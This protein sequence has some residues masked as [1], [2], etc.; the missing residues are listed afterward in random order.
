MNLFILYLN[1]SGPI[2]DFFQ[3]LFLLLNQTIVKRYTIF[4][5]FSVWVVSNLG[6]L[7]TK[8]PYVVPLSSDWHYFWWEVL[9]GKQKSIDLPSPE[10]SIPC[11]FY[12]ILIYVRVWRDFAHAINVKISVDLKIIRLASIQPGEPVQS[13]EVLKLTAEGF[14]A[15]ER[16]STPFLTWRWM[17]LKD[18]EGR[19]PL[20]TKNIPQLSGRNWGSYNHKKLSSANNKNEL[21]RG[22]SSSRWKCGQP[23]PSFQP[24]K[25][26]TCS[27]M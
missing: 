1:F 8:L 9:Y 26:S 5:P 22:P 21:G 3:Y 14:E 2:L 18:K 20:G 27:T 16:F 19:Q 11:L 13:R 15:S 17:G 24:E 7:E 4:C 25:R 23:A 6:L 12:Q 10:I